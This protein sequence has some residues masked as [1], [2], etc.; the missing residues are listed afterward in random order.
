[1]SVAQQRAAKDAW[2]AECAA[3]YSSVDEDAEEDGGVARCARGP[4]PWRPDFFDVLDEAAAELVV[5]PGDLR[6]TVRWMEPAA[7]RDN[8]RGSA[9]LLRRVAPAAPPVV[10]P[11]TRPM[12]YYSEWQEYRDSDVNAY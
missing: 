6:L 8:G 11:P 4:K 2:K 10:A 7:G 9:L 5:L 3:W 1:M 12:P